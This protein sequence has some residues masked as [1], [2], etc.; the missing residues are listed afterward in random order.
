MTDISHLP[1]ERFPKTLYGLIIARCSRSRHTFPK[2][3]LFHQFFSFLCGI[4]TTSV[5][6]ISYGIIRTQSIR[7]SIISYV[8]TTRWIIVANVPADTMSEQMLLSRLLCLSFT[9][10]QN[11]SN[12]TKKPLPSFL[13]K[14]PTRNC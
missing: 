5:T 7:I 10:W 6:M 13:P 9:E 14:R 1:F 3:V 2:T 12:R 4:L 11:F 8:Q